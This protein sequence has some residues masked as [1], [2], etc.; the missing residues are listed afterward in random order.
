MCDDS[1]NNN[2]QKPGEPN[3]YEIMDSIDDWYET[4]KLG[5]ETP[6]TLQDSIRSLSMIFSCVLADPKTER[7][8]KLL[9]NALHET[10]ILHDIELEMQVWK[11][12][13]QINIHNGNGYYAQVAFHKALE[14]AKE[15][16]TLPQATLEV[17]AGLLHAQMMHPD[18]TLEEEMITW[19]TDLLEETEDPCLQGELTQAL[20][21][22]YTQRGSYDKAIAY[23]KRAIEHWKSVGKVIE[24]ARTAFT[25]AAAY[26]AAKDYDSAQ[27]YLECAKD[28]F[29]K[30]TFRRQ[31]ALVA[32]EQASL[33]YEQG[34]HKQA[35]Q[36]FYEALK[37]SLALDLKHIIAPIRHGLALAQMALGDYKGAKKNLRLALNWWIKD[38]N[39]Y[40][41]AWICQ[42]MG[43]LYYCQGKYACAHDWWRRGLRLCDDLSNIE[44]SREIV[45]EIEENLAALE[46]KAN[47]L[48]NNE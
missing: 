11:Q 46:E 19:V 13:G 26:R 43:H 36:W 45:D 12:I 20:A 25:I 34:Q 6:H 42:A 39:Y 15:R 14:R 9:L 30:T 38:R 41:Q 37:E 35:I 33:Y 17:Y 2:G 5:I 48:S 44:A 27:R 23:G 10:H 22:A 16:G 24:M 32:H 31:Y 47:G 21:F 28:L 7:W 29:G 8:N 3:C 1:V 18:D 40:Q 4:I